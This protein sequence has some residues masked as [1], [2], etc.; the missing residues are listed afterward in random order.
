LEEVQGELKAE[1]RI[2]GE[3]EKQLT[4]ALTRAE[5]AVG[6]A[7]AYTRSDQQQPS[8]NTRQTQ[9]LRYQN[10]LAHQNSTR[11][12]KLEP[13]GQRDPRKIPVPGS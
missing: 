2:R 4:E 11:A 6:A 1:Q 10:R 5:Q 3:V 12:T 13:T 7:A 8:A 9:L